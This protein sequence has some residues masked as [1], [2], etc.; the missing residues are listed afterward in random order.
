MT[1]FL[2]RMAICGAL[3]KNEVTGTALSLCSLHKL[4]NIFLTCGERKNLFE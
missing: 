3:A 2:L 1:L 4:S